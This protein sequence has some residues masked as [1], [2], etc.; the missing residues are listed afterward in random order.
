MSRL[1]KAS[2]GLLGLTILLFS[3]FVIVNIGD[4]EIGPEARARLAK[5][6]APPPAV[7]EGFKYQLGLFSPLDANVLEAGSAFYEKALARNLTESVKAPLDLEMKGRMKFCVKSSGYCSAADRKLH[8]IEIAQLL[9]DNAA[10]LAR[11][12]RLMKYP[13]A[14]SLLKP[15]VMVRTHDFPLRLLADLKRLQWSDLLARKEDQTVLREWQESNRFY[16]EKLRYPQ[17][18]LGT[19]LTLDTLGGNRAFMRSAMQDNPRLKPSPEVLDSVVVKVPLK[20]IDSNLAVAE[21]EITEGITQMPM[22]DGFFNLASDPPPKIDFMK[23]F[24]PWFRRHQ[25]VNEAERRLSAALA[26]GC[27]DSDLACPRESWFSFSKALVNPAGNFVV[28][29]MTGFVPLRLK[30]MHKRYRKLSQPFSE[31]EPSS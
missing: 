30:D 11:Y 23:A 3:I 7:L 6:Q 2:L 21:L 18:M 19:L 12:D 17:H 26:D 20:E 5:R 1:K 25:T 31:M 22:R 27:I 13:G 8:A 28:G 9:K 16:Q 29:V 24:E 4:E 14:A 10:L 15:S